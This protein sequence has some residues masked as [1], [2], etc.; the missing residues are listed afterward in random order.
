MAG[1]RGGP[2]LKGDLGGDRG[3][4]D[5]PGTQAPP[6][7]P[8]AFAPPRPWYSSARFLVLLVGLLIVY[9]Y[10]WR[11]TKINL[12]ELLI[13]TK[14]VRPFVVDLFRPDVAS[15]G[16]HRQ[17]VQLGMSVDAAVAPEEMVP[18]PGG[19]QLLVPSRVTAVPLHPLVS[20]PGFP[21]HPTRTAFRGE[22]IGNPQQVPPLPT[23]TP[24]PLLP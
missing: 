6:P 23:D 1:K 3:K 2:A 18:P 4:V 21:P 8:P 7:A 16:V 15:R 9:A 13:G 10:G 11:V 20:G 14:F 22:P 19:P 5:D 12:S 24:G 17:E